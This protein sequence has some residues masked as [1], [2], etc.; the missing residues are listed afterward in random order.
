MERKSK[1]ILRKAGM[2]L[3]LV[4]LIFGTVPLWGETPL[5]THCA[6]F[7]PDA[8]DY[9][10]AIHIYLENSGNQP[11]EIKEMELNGKSVGILVNEEIVKEPLKFREKYLEVKNQE[12]MWYRIWPNPIPSKGV[13][14]VIV[15]LATFPKKPPVVNFLYKEPE[16]KPSTLSMD[17]PIEKSP[18]RMSYV[19]FSEDLKA[20]YVY[21]RKETEGDVTLSDTYLDGRK[22]EASLFSP[23]FFHNLS[24]IKIELPK[25][26]KDGSF[27]TIK[28]TS[29]RGNST[30]YQV[31]VRRPQ[32]VLGVTDFN[33]KYADA[34]K[35]LLMNTW[36]PWGGLLKS[37]LDMLQKHNMK[38]ILGSFFTRIVS[39]RFGKRESKGICMVNPEEI[40]EVKNHPAL[41]GF[42]IQGDEPDAHKPWT[43]YCREAE[44]AE[45]FCRLLAPCP[46][47]LI[48][49]NHSGT[50]RNY[51]TFGEIPQ[52]ITTH[53]YQ[54]P[55][56]KG[57]NTEKAIKGIKYEAYHCREASYPH[58][59]YYIPGRVLHYNA[60]GGKEARIEAYYAI[61]EGIKG[62]IYWPYRFAVSARP[63]SMYHKRPQS[64]WDFSRYNFEV[65][66]VHAELSMA[67]ALLFKGDVI[68]LAKTDNPDIDVGSILSGENSI[69]LTL[70]N[71]D[72]I[73][74]PIDSTKEKLFTYNPQKNVEVEVALPPWFTVKDVFV[75]D[76]VGP[77][78]MS[79][80]GSRTTTKLKFPQIDLTRMV[81]ITQDEDLYKRIR[82]RFKKEIYPKLA[83][84]EMNK[85]AF[86]HGLSW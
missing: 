25:P 81:V 32:F 30:A 62:L 79:Y 75:I 76:Y 51:Y 82:S 10:G 20:I 31:K 35:P 4:F 53:A 42:S 85:E 29:T 60:R 11:L 33:E 64:E 86:W 68:T 48:M 1:G 71:R 44:R 69:V 58:P 45:E 13:S 73:S 59:P 37:N 84:D 14:Q 50:P 21:L 65:S 72:F 56:R 17:V 12:V 38:A 18:F 26:L 67:G 23:D 2:A 7:R 3:F 54:L 41:A 49:L 55:T 80:E 36:A 39:R 83:L 40:E 9:A 43:V 8:V 63:W 74:E 34:Y 47:S 24:L 57:S 52:A 6:Y 5:S 19:G 61:L 46:Y 16:E 77:Q 27:H 22:V 70:I 15:R 78:K 66:K 28:A